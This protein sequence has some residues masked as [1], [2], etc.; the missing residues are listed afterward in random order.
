MIAPARGCHFT[1]VTPPDLLPLPAAASDPVS[2]ELLCERFL[3]QILR[4]CA[5]LGGP[6][7][8]AEDAAHETM[9]VVI[10]RAHTIRD[11]DQMLPWVY[12][13]TRRVVSWQRRKSMWTRFVPG[14][15]AESAHPMRDPERDASDRQERRAVWE[16]LEQL[17]PVLR[18]VLVL[19][20][21][22]DRTDEAVAQ[23]VGV[24]TGTVKSRLRRARARF[25]ETAA[26]RGLADEEGR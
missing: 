21:L 12:G 18:E 13:V 5:R 24:P 10:R 9:L 3:P 6:L 17:D 8:D 4:W 16:L 22:E 26:A 7:V 1:G 15:H 2:P 25:A 19:C 23:L 11:P 20:D 14:F